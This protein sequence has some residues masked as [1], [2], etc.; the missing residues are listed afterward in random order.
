MRISFVALPIVLVACAPTPPQMPQPRYNQGAASLQALSHLSQASMV[1]VETVG[2]ENAPAVPGSGWTCYDARVTR[3]SAS[4]G[5]TK[6]S[7][8]CFRTP[9]ECRSSA[10][11]VAT[12]NPG[13]ANVSPCTSHPTASCTY[14]WF[15]DGTGRNTCSADVDDCRSRMVA[16]SGTVP[17]VARPVKQTECRE[18]K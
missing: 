6:T 15:S 12:A 4:G 17:G 7:R 1:S 10:D 16:V 9:A 2:P 13:Q 11:G 8:P 18:V 3:A 5:E 14:L